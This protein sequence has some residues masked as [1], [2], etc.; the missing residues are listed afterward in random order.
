MGLLVDAQNKII[1]FS[2]VKLTLFGAL[3]KDSAVT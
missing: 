3:H 2:V 1:G